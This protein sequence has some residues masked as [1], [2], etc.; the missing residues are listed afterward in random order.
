MGLKMGSGTTKK[1]L[2]ALKNNQRFGGPNN[3]INHGHRYS[4]MGLKKCKGPQIYS[5]KP[6]K[7][8]KLAFILFL[9]ILIK[10]LK[11]LIRPLQGP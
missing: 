1:N 2:G 7:A 8:I 5:I 9:V 4:L 6:P 10:K 11:F 3:S